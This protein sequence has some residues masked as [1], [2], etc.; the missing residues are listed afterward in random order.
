DQAHALARAI[1]ESEEYQTYHRLKDEVMS[2]ETVA[3][4]IKEYK[5]LQVTIQM[6]VM[7]GRNADADDM[8]R[9]SGINSLLFSNRKYRN[10]SW[11][12]C[13]CR[14]RLEISSR[15]L[16]RQWTWTCQFLD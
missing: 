11:R 6:A 7:Q 2:D 10:I 5:K 4:L 16:P 8:Q 12:K 15:L 13:G 3:A 1:R 9:F 14:W